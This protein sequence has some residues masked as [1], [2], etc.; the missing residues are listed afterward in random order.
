VSDEAT[1]TGSYDLDLPNGGKSY[2]IG[3]V[4]EQGPLTENNKIL[5][6]MEEGKSPENPQNLLFIVNNTFVNHH[7]TGE[8]MFIGINENDR[9]PAII[10]NNIFYGPGNV[11]NQRNAILL[12]NFFVDPKFVDDPGY[13]YH[14]KK[15]SRVIGAGMDP[16]EGMDFPL[17]PEFQYVHPACGETLKKDRPLDIG[18]FQF[19]GGGGT[20]PPDAPSRCTAPLPGTR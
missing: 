20:L 9:I 3:N 6:Y 1:G 12:G 19:G 13:D 16:P 10:R 18:A 15:G 4:I 11:T 17:R 8:N 7:L 14:V 2:G 5:T